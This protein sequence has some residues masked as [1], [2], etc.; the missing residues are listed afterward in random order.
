MGFLD[1]LLGKSKLPKPKQ[2]RLFAM[3]TAYVTM[4]TNLSLV[5]KGAGICFKPLEASRFLST[6]IEIGELLQQSIKDTNTQY[7]I[8]KD[9]Y[10]Y[11]WIVLND[12]EFEDIVPTLYM[13]SETLKEHDFGEQLLCAVFK[14]MGETDIYWIY[15]FKQATFY[16][17][18]PWKNKK[19][20][21]SYEFRLRA[22]M[23]KE[24]PIEKDVG[25]W[26]PMW[27]IP[28]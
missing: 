4:S 6:E 26:Y 16:P 17:F 1:T 25:R 23:E 10:D 27:D 19:R 5:S 3:S 15:N 8:K 24:L 11:M 14:F 7:S 21:T 12:P 28:L 9:S 2:D 22:I 20:D 13:V 18:I